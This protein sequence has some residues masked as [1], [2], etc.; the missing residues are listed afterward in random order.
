MSSVRHNH[1]VLI[2]TFVLVPILAGTAAT[3]APAKIARE[4]TASAPKAN[5]KMAASNWQSDYKAGS[6]IMQRLADTDF[7][8][9]ENQ[10]IEGQKKHE[11]LA[12]AAELKLLAALEAAQKKQA[13][14]QDIANILMEL[15]KSLV[16]QKRSTEA[17]SILLSAKAMREKHFPKQSIE[18]A[19][20]TLALVGIAQGESHQ[21]VAEDLAIE[22]YNTYMNLLP[23][24]DPRFCDVLPVIGAYTRDR[25]ERVAYYT[26]FVASAERKYGKTSK[27]LILPMTLCA[28][29]LANNHQHAEAAKMYERA[30]KL[31]KL[32][33]P[34]ESY[35][36][37]PTDKM[38][39]QL[40]LA[41]GKV[42]YHNCSEEE[43]NEEGR[44]SQLLK[45]KARSTAMMIEQHRPS[46]REKYNL[47]DNMSMD[48]A[49]EQAQTLAAANNLAAAKVEWTRVLNFMND[50]GWFP[51]AAMVPIVKRFTSLADICIGKQEFDDA[52]SLMRGAIKFPFHSKGDEA[53][54]D[55]TAEK[56][57]K[58]LS[59]T[60]VRRCRSFLMYAMERVDETR[61]SKYH[62]WMNQ[63]PPQEHCQ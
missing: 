10:A 19:D 8:K 44:R 53:L 18:V 9:K 38:N 2:G 47:F 58:H 59:K 51:T 6:A 20:S 56:L 11:S 48:K 14:E 43:P 36:T 30:V 15:G 23:Y 49:L 17:K 21:S 22:A 33:P 12:H 62:D 42:S 7:S 34:T 35:E 46:A 29:M 57:F 55:G 32:H 40:Q 25:K 31:R 4:A 3:A 13:K 54:I 52:D 61:K 24:N 5:S 60:D 16:W 26:Q 63:L 37:V 50:P 1:F 28:A 41:R 27:E 39:E 45:G